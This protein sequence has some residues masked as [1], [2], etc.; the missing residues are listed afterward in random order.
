MARNHLLVSHMTTTGPNWSASSA[1]AMFV[2]CAVA[3]VMCASHGRRRWRRLVKVPWRRGPDQPVIGDVEPAV[4]GEVLVWQR[5]ILMGEK[6]Q[7][8]DFSGAI[9]YDSDG[10]IVPPLGHQVFL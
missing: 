9:I 1:A 5:N 7:L 6:C 4:T 3:L 8:P 10:K 2:V